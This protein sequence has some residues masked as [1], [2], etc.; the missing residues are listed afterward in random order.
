METTKIV[1]M[2]AKK[3]KLLG[4]ARSAGNHFRL[5]R[6]GVMRAFFGR[7]SLKRNLEF[8]KKNLEFRN[9]LSNL[10]SGKTGRG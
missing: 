9:S 4:R 8:R 3:C 5:G 1:Y 2:Y 10:G 6:G 7:A